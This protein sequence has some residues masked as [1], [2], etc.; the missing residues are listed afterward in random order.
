MQNNCVIAVMCDTYRIERQ[1]PQQQ[2][3][4]DK[5]IQIENEKNKKTLIQS[6]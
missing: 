5:Y 4:I 6:S 3:K 1:Q 2:P